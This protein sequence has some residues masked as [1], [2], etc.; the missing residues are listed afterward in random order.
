MQLNLN[1]EHIEDLKKSGVQL[2]TI[3]NAKIYSIVEKKEL[4]KILPKVQ[5]QKVN[6][7]LAFPYPH[8]KD[9]TRYKLFPA[10]KTNNG[11]KKYHQNVKGVF[12]YIPSGFNFNDET[13]F[14]TE[15]EKKALRGI[16][17]GLN[18]MAVG[19]VWMYSEKD[20]YD[21]K[22]LAETMKV[23]QWSGKKV[24]IIPDSD[25]FVNEDIRRATYRLGRFLEKENAKVS[26]TTFNI[27]DET[28]RIGL[29]DYLINHSA[30]S[31]IGE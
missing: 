9:V 15:G 12:P 30:S 6:S 5:A 7:L 19:G 1:N 24:I 14:I 28:E 16:Q 25:F 18:C 8:F 17:E 22:H 10:I 26:I 27:K 21:I 3:M 13:I 23:I 2:E 11:T 4:E 31:L 20:E 29:D